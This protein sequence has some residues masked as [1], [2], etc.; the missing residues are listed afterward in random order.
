M[1]M[2]KMLIMILVL[3]IVLSLVQNGGIFSLNAGVDRIKRATRFVRDTVGKGLQYVKDKTGY[4]LEDIPVDKAMNLAATYYYPQ[5]T[6]G[7]DSKFGL[8]DVI[9]ADKYFVD[10]YANNP[11]PYPYD[12]Y[13]Y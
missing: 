6:Y 9:K 13:N 7:N 10:P 12:P 4:G 5:Q 8:S 11:Y 1:K 3:L 2:K